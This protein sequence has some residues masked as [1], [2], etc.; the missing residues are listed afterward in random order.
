MAVG[1]AEDAGFRAPR[2][3][4]RRARTTNWPRQ[5]GWVILGSLKIAVDETVA[6]VL[7]LGRGRTKKGYFWAIAPMTGPGVEPTRPPSP[8]PMRRAAAPSTR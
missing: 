5:D 7:D 4:A 8:T 2:V 1:T 6:P 3:R